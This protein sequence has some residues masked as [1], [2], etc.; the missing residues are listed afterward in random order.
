MLKF[1]FHPGMARQGALPVD[2]RAL[3]AA[4]V[5]VKHPARRMTVR[6]VVTA[7][8]SRGTVTTGPLAMTGP[9]RSRMTSPAK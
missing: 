8:T 4:I 3:V 7:G 6:I 1:H 9:E 2:M 5:L